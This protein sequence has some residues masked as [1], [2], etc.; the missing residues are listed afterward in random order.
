MPLLLQNKWPSVKKPL[1]FGIKC[2]FSGGCLFWLVSSI[3]WGAVLQTLQGTNWIILTAAFMVFTTR[4][5]PCAVRWVQVARLS[6]FGIS[7]SE[8]ILWY[9]VGGFFNTFLPTGR[10]GDVVRGLIVSRRHGFSFSGL[11]TTVF[12]ERLIGLFVTLF[13][14][15]MAS[16]IAAP[17]FDQVQGALISL[18]TLGVVLAAGVA[19]LF[20][21]P[22]QALVRRM[23]K[24]VGITPVL[25]L[26]E[27][28]FSTLRLCIASPRDLV[29]AALLSGLNQV[30]FIFSAYLI[31]LAIPGFEPPWYSY[32]VI[33]PLIFLSELL[34]SLGGYGIREVGFVV[35]FGWFGVSQD[36]SGA[37]A[38]LQLLF[39]LGSALIGAV[40][41]V[42]TKSSPVEKQA[43]EV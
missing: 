29:W 26:A 14:V 43:A 17:H 38:L 18:I 12:F 24:A 10:G 31:G 2:L 22:F 23:L 33:I 1:S 21:P 9:Y 3:Q 4:L 35:L 34:P 5:I 6:G 36:A 11:M 15:L 19:L 40:A 25:S 28:V 39:L 42:M 13:F 8:S 27:T 41:F 7:Y 20:Y 32:A 30:V 37:Y 16:L